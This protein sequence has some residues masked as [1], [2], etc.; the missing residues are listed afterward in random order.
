LEIKIETEL[1]WF[2]LQDAQLQATF[3]VALLRK[4]SQFDFGE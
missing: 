2:V 3:P 4:F 1:L